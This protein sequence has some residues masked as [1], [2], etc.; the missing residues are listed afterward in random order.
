MTRK[1]TTRHAFV[2]ARIFDGDVWHDDAVL[3][4]EGAR[5]A[6][7]VPAGDVSSDTQTTKLDGGILAPGFVDLQVNGGGG[8]MLND[9]Q[10][11]ESDED[12]L[13]SPPRRARPWC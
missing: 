7:I 8:V 9:R 12:V 2:G 13:L 11:V 6:G 3:L 4:T 5:V 1:E 10:D